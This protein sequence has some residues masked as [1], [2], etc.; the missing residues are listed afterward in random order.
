MPDDFKGDDTTIDPALVEQATR[1]NRD[2]EETGQPAE[3]SCAVVD[4]MD[5][6][7]M[8]WTRYMAT[9]DSQYQQALQTV[10]RLEKGKPPEDRALKSSLAPATTSIS[11]S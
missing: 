2:L 4:E 5:T 9:L 11:K 1:L 3:A 7:F 8:R 10:R 6:A